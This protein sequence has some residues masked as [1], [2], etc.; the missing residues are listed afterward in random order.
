MM[1]KRVV[2]AVHIHSCLRSF[3]KEKIW[4]FHCSFS[5][6]EKA[7]Q[8]DLELEKRGKKCRKSPR[9]FN[10]YKL[11]FFVTCF[12]TKKFPTFCPFYGHCDLLRKFAA[13]SLNY[14]YFLLLFWNSSHRQLSI[15]SASSTAASPLE[16]WRIHQDLMH[17]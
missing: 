11:I 9:I 13:K 16:K 14:Y 8:S 6:R 12:L 17:S 5:F 3:S 1:M 10:L 7:A 15:V 2:V 4:K